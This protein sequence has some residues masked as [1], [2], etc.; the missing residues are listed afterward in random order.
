MPAFQGEASDFSLLLGPPYIVAYNI[1]LSCV[2]KQTEALFSPSGFTDSTM[3]CFILFCPIRIGDILAQNIKFDTCLQ[4]YYNEFNFYT[5]VF[6]METIFPLE[7]LAS[8]DGNIYER[9]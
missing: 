4:N 2:K 5:E 7:Q 9:L 1:P 6:L 8:F 3:P